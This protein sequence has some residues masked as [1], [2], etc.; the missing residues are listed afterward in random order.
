MKHLL[1]D[2]NADEDL[3][4]DEKAIRETLL[5]ALDAAGAPIRGMAEYS[6]HPM[7]YSLVVLLAESHASIHTWPEKLGARIDFFSC[8]EKPDFDAFCSVLV[9]RGFTWC[10]AHADRIVDRSFTW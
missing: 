8:S 6:F 4:N 9:E 7:G 10:G 5:A 3:L 1:L 2:V